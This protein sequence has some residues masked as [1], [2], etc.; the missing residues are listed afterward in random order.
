MHTPLYDSKFTDAMPE[1]LAQE[2]WIQ[3]ID[4][5]TQKRVQ[6][7][8]DEDPLLQIY[9]R[10]RE[11]PEWVIDFMAVNVRAEDY[12]ADDDIETKRDKIALAFWANNIKGTVTATEILANSIFGSEK[13]RVEEWWDYDDD[14]G[15]FQIVITDPGASDAQ[16][17][18]F[19]GR[20]DG[21][22]R[23]SAWLR[24]FLILITAPAQQLHFGTATVRSRRTVMFRLPGLEGVAKLAAVQCR[25]TSYFIDL[26]DVGRNSA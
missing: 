14:P 12:R 5:V 3:A 11:L 1:I 18:K 25:R 8:M 4:N 21:Y 10:L 15:Y 24:R 16:M 6:Q 9:V 7:W 17:E 22:K 2:P 23:L 20:M 13:N 19:I 26:R